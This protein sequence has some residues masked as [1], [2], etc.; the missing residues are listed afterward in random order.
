MNP[1]LIRVAVADDH[2]VILFGVEHDLAPHPSISIDGLARNSTQLIALL[3]RN[4]IDVVVCDYAMPGGVYG[5]GMALLSLIAQR[6]PHV[7]IV[8]LTMQENP[9]IVQALVTQVRCIVSKSDMSHHLLQAVH[10]AF[11]NERY[12]SPAMEALLRTAQPR[13][14]HAAGH[15]LLTNRELEV[16]RLF[17]SGLTVTEIAARLRRSKKTISAQKTAAMHKLKIEREVDLVYYGM[18]T[19]LIPS[20]MRAPTEPEA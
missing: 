7:R 1:V 9:A 5:D 3:N 20:A 19:G 12:V 17:V 10:A 4:V 11:A 8:V 2:P 14:S 15:P 13:R 18:E 6:Y 16:V